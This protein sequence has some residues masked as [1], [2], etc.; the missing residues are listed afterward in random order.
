MMVAQRT[1]LMVKKLVSSP[2]EPRSRDEHAGREVWSQDHGVEGQAKFDQTLETTR[3]YDKQNNPTFTLSNCIVKLDLVIRACA[4]LFTDGKRGHAE[5]RIDGPVP[6]VP[7][8][9]DSSSPKFCLPL[10]AL[11]WSVLSGK[12]GK[13]GLI[14]VRR[15]AKESNKCFFA[16][17]DSRNIFFHGSIDY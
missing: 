2:E 4:R 11:W 7:L 1:K 15:K 3:I 6:K 8:P 17:S 16:Q 12:I 5:H 10:H 9:P 14:S 13:F